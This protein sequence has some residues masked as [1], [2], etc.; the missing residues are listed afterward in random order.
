MINNLR[1]H[2]DF[3]KLFRK[4]E[5]K[6]FSVISLNFWKL[7][8]IMFITFCAIGF[9]NGS[10]EYLKEKMSDPFINWVDI[11][12]NYND[13]ERIGKIL[14]ELNEESLSEKFCY[15]NI[16]GYDRF[17]LYF[18]NDEENGAFRS[19]G[20]TIDINNPLLDKIFDDSNLITGRKFNSKDDIGLVVTDEFLEKYNYDLNSPHAFM[21]Q[22]ITV[23][24]DRNVPI[25]IIAVVDN[26]PNLVHFV[27]TPYF[28]QL[29]SNQEK[30]S[31]FNPNNE[32][33]LVCFVEGDSSEAYT[34]KNKISN[35]LENHEYY[36]QLS[37][38]CSQ[39]RKNK[40]SYHEGYNIIISLLPDPLSINVLDSL[41]NNINN[42]GFIQKNN[43]HRYH[44]YK[45][46]PC[47]PKK[48]FDRISVN[49]FDLDK[50]KDFQ[51]F[52]YKTHNIEIDLAQI[53]AKENYNFV[54]KLTFIISSILIIFSIISI[55]MFVSHIFKEH[56]DKIKKN[57][58]TFKAF[59]LNNF[60]L[61]LIYLIIIYKFIGFSLLVSFVLTFIFGRLKGLKF[62]ISLFQI[63]LEK[64]YLYF[65]L[66]DISTY[67]ALVLIVCF[68]FTVL[69]IKTSILLNKTPGDL[70]YDRDNN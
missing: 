25:P 33:K 13:S 19:T 28:Y 58:G 49:F 64:N 31:P 6:E 59:G 63:N 41:F 44:N 62:F 61:K 46:F 47:S 35:Y 54:S 16:T 32:K 65:K 9:A 10:L 5:G 20:R 51:E 12:V 11:G 3:R 48:S 37:P 27:S 22:P 52:L 17:F 14:Q 4:K 45:L 7:V 57:I 68:S 60:T 18:W 21:L 36:K 56:L 1:I 38:C 70:I 8:S 40:D 30:P 55:T 69:Y 50:I 67:I 34:F 26:L 29:R 24:E 2:K 43:L 53:K 66:M 15:N 39:I 42:S 23:K